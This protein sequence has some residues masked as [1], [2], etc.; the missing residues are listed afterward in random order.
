M[1]GGHFNYSNDNLCHDIFGWLISADY[2]ERGFKKSSLA[3]RLNPL[4]DLVIS[5]LVFDVFCL[6]HSFDWYKSGDTCEETY[7]EDVTRFKNKWLPH[8]SEQRTK[9]IVDD[10]ISNLREKLYQAFNLK[11][12]EDK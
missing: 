5:E 6:L 8:F 10:E 7:R 1:S 11:M 4:E 9:E 3:R 2:G 12:T